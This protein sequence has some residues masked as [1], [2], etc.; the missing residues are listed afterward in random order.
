[1]EHIMEVPPFSQLPND[2]NV[3]GYN[4]FVRKSAHNFP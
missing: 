4:W 2:F 1:M 3:T